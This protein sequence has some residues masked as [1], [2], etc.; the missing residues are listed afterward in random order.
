M[1]DQQELKFE[2]QGQGCRECGEFKVF[3]EFYG[4]PGKYSLDCKPCYIEKVISNQKKKP[5][6]TS[7]TAHKYY[8]ANKDELLAK[9]KTP[10]RLEKNR[11]NYH[12]NKGNRLEKKRC[13]SLVT[14]ALRRGVDDEGNLFVRMPCERCGSQLRVH[15]HHDDYRNPYI[16]MWLCSYHHGERHRELTIMKKT[17]ELNA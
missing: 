7:D 16:V 5:Q 17:R 15:G 14:L 4:K 10:E 3:D 13:K 1:L 2:D 8:M 9:A 6:Q 11:K 12:D